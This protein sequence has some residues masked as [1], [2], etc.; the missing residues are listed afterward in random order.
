MRETTRKWIRRCKGPAGVALIFLG[1]VLAAVLIA[2]YV[3]PGSQD[4]AFKAVAGVTAVLIAVVV[5]WV[6]TPLTPL[7]SAAAGIAARTIREHIKRAN[8]Y[9]V[10]IMVPIVTVW[11]AALVLFGAGT[12]QRQA[13]AIGGGVAVMLIG[14]LLFRNQLRCPRCGT[15]LR[16][17]RI[18]KL[19][20]RSRD[21][22]ATADLWDACPRCGVSFNEAWP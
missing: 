20:R 4:F 11:G 14:V 9:F 7:E 19:G 21:T 10:R 5:A 12:M 6:R 15:D 8:A 18:A 3:S 1:Q 22:R 16:K 17:E 13:L 2:L